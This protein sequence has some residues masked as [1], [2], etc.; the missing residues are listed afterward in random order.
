MREDGGALAK[1]VEEQLIEAL[2]RC[3]QAVVVLALSFIS[4]HL[5]VYIV[6]LRPWT[7]SGSRLLENVVARTGLGLLWFSVVLVPI[8][9]VNCHSASFR[10][11]KLVELVVPTLVTGLF[12]QAIIF[13][14]IMRPKRR[15]DA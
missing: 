6:L 14:I 9:L 4:G 3:P 7:R 13:A 12:V 10:Y 1:A 11:E 8:Y 2:K 5:W 15:K